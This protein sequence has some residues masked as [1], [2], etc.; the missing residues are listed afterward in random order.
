MFGFVETTTKTT[1]FTKEGENLA[2]GWGA[3]VT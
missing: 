3:E 2:V 1:E